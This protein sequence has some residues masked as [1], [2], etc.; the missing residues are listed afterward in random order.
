M[1]I[2]A[3]FFAL[4][5]ATAATVGV[6][7]AASRYELVLG[8]ASSVVAGSSAAHAV[9]GNEPIEILAFSFAPSGSVG[10]HVGSASS[11]IGASGHEADLVNVE[12]DVRSLPAAQRARLL[13]GTRYS[14]IELIADRNSA[15]SQSSET[16]ALREVI[17]EKTAFGTGDLG[18]KLTVTFEYAQIDR[19]LTTSTL[20]SPTLRSLSVPGV[21]TVPVVPTARPT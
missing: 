8:P 14:E 1:K 5:G 7:S 11:H 21:P 16:I 18:P 2:S 3:A 9:G 20:V 10:Q 4:L 19:K 13:E 17:V 6:A 12:I 15:S